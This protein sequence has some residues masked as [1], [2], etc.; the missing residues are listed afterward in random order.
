MICFLFFRLV[1]QKDHWMRDIGGTVFYQLI[2]LEHSFDSLIEGFI[3]FKFFMS[4]IILVLLNRISV[5][6][7]LPKTL[8]FIVN[9]FLKVS[10]AE[11]IT[12][13]K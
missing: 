8:E 2:K 13:G 9:K 12:T 6:L 4:S 1:R 10:F 3:F 5:K 11:H 7:F